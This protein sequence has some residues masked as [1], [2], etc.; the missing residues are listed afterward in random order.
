MTTYVAIPN[1]DIDQDSPVTQPLM[2]ALRDNPLA[3]FE[4]DATAPRLALPALEVLVAGTQIRSRTDGVAAGGYLFAFIQRGT[5]RLTFEHASATNRTISI[6]RVRGGVETAV[7]TF[8]S[9]AG[10]VARSL[11]ISVLPG[12][13]I[14]GTFAPSGGTGT[15]Q[16]WR[17]QTSGGN[18]WPG[19]QMAVEGNNV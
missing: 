4:G 11:D 18:L 5:I 2:T 19:S 3:M 13:A 7:A 6:M 14:Y 1:G 17:Y 12:D 10:Y 16:L 9:V 8:A 15:V